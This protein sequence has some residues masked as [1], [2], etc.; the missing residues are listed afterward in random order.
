MKQRHDF[1]IEF[2][3]KWRQSGVSAVVSPTFPH[4]AFPSKLADDM[5]L[6]CEYTFLWS[7]LHYPGGVVPVT[8]VQEDEQEYSGDGHNDGWTRLLNESAKNSEGMPITVTVYSHNFEDEKALAVMQ[9]LDQKI[10]F[11][12]K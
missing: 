1:C 2:S 7:I 4:C 6:M 3:K 12:M 10:G 9:S 5:G 11:R 8:T